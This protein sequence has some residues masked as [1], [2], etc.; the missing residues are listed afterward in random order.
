[1]Y[2][3]RCAA[4][5]VALCMLPVCSSAQ[6][7]SGTK[8]KS[9]ETKDVDPL[10]L[11]VLKAV[12]QPIEQAQAFTF[13]ALVSEEQLATNGQ[14]VTFFHTTEITVQRPDK[15]HFRRQRDAHEGLLIGRPVTVLRHHG[16]LSGRT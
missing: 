8:S 1:M 10:A 4:V 11:D 12:T 16:Y 6:D 14:I 3:I 5:L 2:R 7:K 13:K 9:T 15:V